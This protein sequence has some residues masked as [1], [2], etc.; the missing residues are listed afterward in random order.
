VILAIANSP[1]DSETFYIERNNTM[2]H[3]G[4]LNGTYLQVFLLLSIS[5]CGMM[6]WTMPSPGS[7]TYVD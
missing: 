5:S 7:S 3:I 6:S 4:L 2:L 1:R